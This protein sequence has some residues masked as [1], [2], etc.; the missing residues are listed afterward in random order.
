[1]AM[2]ISKF[3]KIIQSK[4][5]WG[6]FA[7]LICVAFVG[8]SAPGSRGRKAARRE[9]KAAQLAGRLFGEEVS[10]IELAHA[11][12]S[13]RLNYT[14]Q[15]GPFRITDDIY[16]VLVT[17]A[18]KRVAM[19]KKARQLGMDV[20]PEQIV[21]MIQSQ[22]IFQNQQTGQFDPN[23]YS[24]ALQQIGQLIRG[25]TP[26]NVEQ[27]YAEEV[28]LRKVARIPAQG[29]L[30]TDEEIQKAF[31]LYTDKLTV[32]YAAIPRSLA[33]TPKVTEEDAKN[34]FALNQEEFRMPEK[35]IVDYVQFAV[36][37]HLENVEATDEMVAG[38]Y[39]NNKQRFLKQPAEDAP[40]DAAPEYQP[41]EEVK[42]SI[43]EQIKQVLAR[44]AAADLA[45]ELVA[46][47]ADETTTFEEATQK[48]GLEIIDDTPAFTLTDPVKG[49]D[50]T[51]PFQRAAFALEKDA[52]HYYSDP[53]VGRDF[54][55]VA[56]L[57][58][59]FPAFL[60]SF[61]IVR[62]A[63]IESAKIAAAE[64]AYVEKA[65]QVHGE[66]MAAL[67]AGTAFADA[68]AKY[69]LE[70]K[71][72]EPFDITSE[73]EDEFG[74]QIKGASLLYGPGKLTDLVAT[75]D[76][77]LVA[78]VA[79]K[80]SGDEATTLPGMRNELAGNIGNEKAAQLVAAWQDALLEE[81]GFEDLLPR[82]NDES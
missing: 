67:K 44:K 31:H 2:M 17:S 38:F 77:Y 45:D 79:E 13:I 27:H 24:A 69:S 73:L 10:R 61:D 5:V 49:I 18:W 25:M 58:K 3:H 32:E 47:L 29:A 4:V 37:D 22:P 39:E 42:D 15:Y 70:L 11:Y 75:P 23:A 12:D 57:T 80:T 71:K 43:T 33:D 51:A 74:Q 64:K 36:A 14:L 76:E 55:Y 34:Y 6:A 7:L 48:L 62:E 50:P 16:E 30:V 46:E 28:L 52:T 63:A 82:S 1:M 54:V 68:I 40:A 21:S 53:I 60:P 66:I 41:L 78:Y 19:L 59:K 65:E 9:Q 81:A 20:T 35:A 56:S 8:V 26:K 72:T